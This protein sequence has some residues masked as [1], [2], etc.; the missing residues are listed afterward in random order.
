MEALA[1]AMPERKCLHRPPLFTPDWSEEEESDGAGATIRFP[2][3][4]ANK[5]SRLDLAEEK[6][7]QADLKTLGGT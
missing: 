7:F 2:V 6:K 1:S 5:L 3:F 4:L